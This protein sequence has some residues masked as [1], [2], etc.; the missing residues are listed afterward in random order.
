MNFE[1]TAVDEPT[2]GRKWAALFQRLWPAYRAWF[3]SDGIE[4]RPT[5]LECRESVQR[6]LPRFVDTYDELAELAGGGDLAARFLSLWCPPAYI[7]GC[8]QVVWPGD[9]PVLLRNYDYAPEASDGIILRSRWNGMRVVAMIDSMAGALDGVNEAGLA[10]SLTFGGRRIVGRGFGAP[11]IVRYILEF[12]ETTEDATAV[13]RS[14]PSFMAHN[15][16]V[17]DRRGEF[18]T[19]YL[20]PDRRPVIRQFPVATNH[21]GSVEWH[22]HARATA[23]LERENYLM[24]RL[25]DRTMTPERLAEAFFRPPLYTRAYE[26]GFGT[27]YTAVYYPQRGLAEYRWPSLT[28]RLG[29]DA[30]EEG[31]RGVHFAKHAEGADA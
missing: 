8:S 16:T 3:L 12:C 10:V 24:F 19:A 28:W 29:I 5:Y 1:F 14:V 6:H 31:T 9:E 18:A 15:I 25:F 20:S 11:I 30:F 26:H 21:Q 17:V 4:P 7:A 2:P 13:L 22:N 23:T 27:I